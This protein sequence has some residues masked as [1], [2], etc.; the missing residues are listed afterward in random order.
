MDT[1]RLEEL[2]RSS[3][4]GEVPLVMMT[5][6]NNTGDNPSRSRTWPTCPGSAIAPKCRSTSTCADGRRTPTSSGPGTCQE[7]RSI[8][9]IG[10]S[11]FD[12][13]DGATMS[14]KKDGLV[15]IGGFVA[16]RDAALSERLKEELIVFEGFPTCTAVSPV[17]TSRR[18]R[19]DSWKRRTSPTSSTGSARCDIS[20]SS[21][22]EPVSRLPP[23][24]GGS[25]DLPRRP[26]VPRAPAKGG[27][28]RKQALV[29]EIYREGGVRTVEVG[30]VMF[31][32][33]EPGRPATDGARP[34][35]D[36]SQGLL[37]GA[38]PVRRR[39]CHRGLRAPCFG[40][41]DEDDVRSGAATTLHRPVRPALR[42]APRIFWS[43]PGCAGRS[44]PIVKCATSWA[45]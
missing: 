33:G 26:P 8:P 38:A 44:K 4:P 13:A 6:T 3:G 20:P 9:R 18:S 22:S 29:V 30:G 14:A 17:G 31:G 21:S 27:V 45:E 42:L 43:R 5:L 11:I 25:W 32:D 37:G 39:S 2:L 40:S 36:P 35:C 23:T 41:R 24:S 34:A 19:W 7:G 15:N 10:R 28:P 16:T 1:G 12:L